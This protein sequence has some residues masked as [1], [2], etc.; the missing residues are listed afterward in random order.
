MTAD[1]PELYTCTSYRLPSGETDER[2]GN[3]WCATSINDDL[4]YKDW[5]WCSGININ[6]VFL[7]NSNFQFGLNLVS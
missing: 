2:L 4:T 7:W 1:G 6:P 3:Q 5:D